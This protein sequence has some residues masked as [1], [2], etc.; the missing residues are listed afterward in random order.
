MY[1]DAD[2]NVPNLDGIIE[3]D[4]EDSKDSNSY[5]YIRIARFEK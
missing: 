2:T 5:G 1:A 3:F 4:S